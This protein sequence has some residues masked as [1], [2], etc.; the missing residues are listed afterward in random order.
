VEIAFDDDLIGA[1]HLIDGFHVDPD[2]SPQ[3]LDHKVDRDRLLFK[4]LG[5]MHLF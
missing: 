5:F 4:D 1:R 3:L 2:G